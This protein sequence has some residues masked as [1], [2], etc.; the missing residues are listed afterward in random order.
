MLT[1]EKI[2]IYKC[3]ESNKKNVVDYSL[4]Q[5]LVIIDLL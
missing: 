5:L 4:M 3:D 1:I 2:T